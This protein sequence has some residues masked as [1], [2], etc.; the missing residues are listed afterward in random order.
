MNTKSNRNILHLMGMDSTKYGGIERFNVELS[1]QLAERGY[2]S[3]FV[4]EK[5]PDVDQF[6]VDLQATGADI[7]EIRSRGNALGFCKQFWKMLHQYEF[8]MMHAHF[9]KARFYAIPIALLYGIKNIVYTFHST[10]EPL[11]DIKWHTRVWYHIFNKYSRIVAVS[12]DIEIVARKNWPNTTIKNIYLGIKPIQVDREAARRDLHLS[13]DVL[14]V[15]CTANYNHIKGLDVL[16]NAVN[17]LKQNNYLNKIVFYVV[18]QTD[19]DK[20]ELQQMIDNYKLTDYF[21]LVGISNCIPKYLCAADIYIQPSRHEGLPLALMEACSAGL[22]IVASRIGG[23]PEVAVEG[24]NALLFEVENVEE[25]AD[26]ILKM[27]NDH[28]I[29]S[30]YGKNSKSVYSANFQLSNNV[31]KLFEYYKILDKK[32]V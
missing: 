28:S 15:M 16:V 2:H 6:V 18:G 5:W 21:R 26:T 17:R 4:Y 30:L 3:V 8:C 10:I 20:V 25:C 1:R 32:S 12:K 27:I 23:I 29:C 22:P 13:N 14:M 11:S 7:V 9:T 24:V 19:Q 31:K